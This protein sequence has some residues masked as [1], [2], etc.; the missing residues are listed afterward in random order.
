MLADCISM[1]GILLLDIGPR[2]DGTIPEQEVAMLKSVG[3]WVGKHQ[4]AVYETKAGI[5]SGHI[6]G[7]TSLSKD[8]STIYV[9]LP[10]R[11]IGS[12][13]FKGLKSR[14]KDARIVG[15]DFSVAWQQYNDISWSE[16]PGV[17]YFDI[18][19]EALDAEITVM[20]IELDEPVKLYCG[21]GQVI[22]FNDNELK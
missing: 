9:Y 4:E 5:P 21:P 22:S 8:G 6:Q 1:G 20:A 18:P 17:Y 19:E 11:P 12:V 7:Y 3:R 14:V 13:E 2:A 15:T 10:Y 16:V